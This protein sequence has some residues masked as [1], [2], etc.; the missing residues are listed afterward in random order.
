MSGNLNAGLQIGV[1][2]YAEFSRTI[3]VARLVHQG[4]PGFS[5]PGI[6]TLGPEVTLDMTA[7]FGISAQGQLLAGV[8]MN[9]ANLGATLD[10]IHP[11][12]STSYGFTPQVTKIFNATGTLTA[13]ASLGLP[14][15]LAFGIDL[16][17]GKY[18]KSIA[19]VDAPSVNAQ[20]SLSAAYSNVN[21]AGSLSV[22]DGQCPG[23]V[24]S[25][26]LENKV[27]LNVLDLRT[28][29]LFDWN[30]PPLASSCIT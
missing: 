24:W 25:I 23:V 11:S 8:T 20:A 3:T 16:L 26:G 7:Q 1:D 9:W 14:V 15:G 18:S 6:I 29:Q 19:L 17:H 22:N 28:Y 21:G 2:A 5:I 10:I 27:E 30:S 12:A 4:I 13:T